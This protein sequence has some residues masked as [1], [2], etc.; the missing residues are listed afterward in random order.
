MSLLAIGAVLFGLFLLIVAAMVWQETRRH[1]NLS[2]VYVIEEAVPFVFGRLSEGAIARLDTDDVL[3]ILEWE[4]HYLQGLEVPRDH[5][6]HPS[7]VAGSEDA[8]VYIFEKTAAA[9]HD[10]RLEDVIEVLKHE[11]AYLV[12]IGAVGSPVEE[13]T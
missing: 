9:G 6:E 4:V 1:P 7:P 10:Y 12:D 2:A 8:I 3:R 5:S 13:A 11:Q